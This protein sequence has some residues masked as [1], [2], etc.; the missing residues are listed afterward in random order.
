MLH[1]ARFMLGCTVPVAC[2]PVHVARCML[3]GARCTLPVHVAC[4]VACC[5]L[6]V[7]RCMFCCTLCS[8]RFRKRSQQ[9]LAGMA[10]CMVYATCL[11]VP[12]ASRVP[13]STPEYLRERRGP[14]KCADGRRS[15]YGAGLVPLEYPKYPWGYSN[16][17]AKEHSI[18]W[19]DCVSKARMVRTTHVAY[20]SACSARFVS[21]AWRW[22]CSASTRLCARPQRLGGLIRIIPPLLGVIPTLMPTTRTLI[23]II[24]PL[25]D[26]IPTLIPTTRTVD[27]D[28]QYP[29][30]CGSPRRVRRHRQ[31][32]RRFGA[33]CH[34]SR[35]TLATGSGMSAAILQRCRLHLAHRGGASDVACRPLLQ[36]RKAA[37]RRPICTAVRCAASLSTT[38]RRPSLPR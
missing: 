38:A 13:Q 11:S 30:E 23:R 37:R 9:A 3:P 25:I 10:C 33:S 15:R 17:I 19:S 27:R 18:A 20:H 5:P 36:R 21:S 6:H 34:V 29:D 35:C 14:R 2:C 28:Y 12:P 26:V 16:P 8:R 32:D 22:S 4:Y 1:V 7:A 31:R 24:P